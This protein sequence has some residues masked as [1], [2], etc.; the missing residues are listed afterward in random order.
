M[1]SDEC[2]GAP[3]NSWTY[4]YWTRENEVPE[5]MIEGTV[6]PILAG[7]GDDDDL[8]GEDIPIIWLKR[9]FWRPR[10]GKGP[11]FGGHS[12]WRLIEE[13]R[14]NMPEVELGRAY[15]VLLCFER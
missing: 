5:E 10:K 1:W 11:K 4:D 9:Q 8:E 3:D 15:D 2:D 7:S 12:G 6:G 13:F 14:R